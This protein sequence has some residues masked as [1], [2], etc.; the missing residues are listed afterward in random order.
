MSTRRFLVSLL[1]LAALTKIQL[2]SCLSIRLRQHHPSTDFVDSKI[3]GC[4]RHKH[5]RT[6]L[7]LSRKSNDDNTD[8]IGDNNN[9]NAPKNNS[10]ATTPLSPDA[11]L[12]LDPGLW[13]SDFLAVI[14]AS[15]LIGLLDIVNS[16]EFIQNG[17]WFQPIPAVPSTLDDLVQRISFFGIT[18]AIASASVFFFANTMATTTTTSTN[19]SDINNDTSV[20]LK[21]N[22]QT[23]AVFGVMQIVGNG[24]VFGLLGSDVNNSLANNNDGFLVDG[25]SAIPWLDVLRNCYYVG[26]STTGLRFLYGRYFLLS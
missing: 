1:Y 14:L 20:I 13:I 17:G 19:S 5:Q 18:W 9:N 6:Q 24:I 8:E 22:V 2:S 7:L 11:S 15:Q 4:S 25:T 23:L 3:H 10:M 26:L 21:R 12:L 16:P